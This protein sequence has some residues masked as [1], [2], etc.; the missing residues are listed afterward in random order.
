MTGTG[1][2]SSRI[3][4]SRSKPFPPSI[5]ISETISVWR[6]RCCTRE[7]A[8][9]IP[10]AAQAFQ[11]ASRRPSTSI[12]AWIASSSTISVHGAMRARCAPAVPS[13]RGSRAGPRLRHGH[14]RASAR[15][16]AVVLRHSRF[17]RQSDPEGRSLPELA[18]HLDRAAVLDDDAARDEQAQAGALPAR[19][20]GKEW[21]EDPIDHVRGNA[22]PRI[23]DLHFDAVAGRACGHAQF[24]AIW[25]RVARIHEQIQECA[26]E[27]LALG[28]HRRSLAERALDLDAALAW[29]LRDQAQRALRDMLDLQEARVLALGPREVHQRL[30]QSRDALDLSLDDPD[31]FPVLLLARRAREHVGVAEDHVHRR[32]DVVRDPRDDLRERRE[33]LGL[34][35]SPLEITPF[36]DVARDD[37]STGDRPRAVAAR[38]Q[39]ERYVERP[40]IA[41]HTLGLEMPDAAAL[42]HASEQLV[43]L[44]LP[45]GRSQPREGIPFDLVPRVAV[46]F[47]RRGIPGQDA[48]VEIGADD[49]V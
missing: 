2:P 25:H 14:H 9:H 13:A 17:A 41:A 37:G 10:V 3:A 22:G 20:G 6:A 24:A 21:L 33:L 45:L 34:A 42:A 40:S 49:R 46:D 4:R 5:Q 44:L 39:A 18:L 30:D 15:S 7:S 26:L 43:V 12:C 35:E 27:S 48:P 36:T 16:V 31:S 8:S 38:R 11:P 19:L 47:L 23:V 29:G 28:E 32:S 1:L